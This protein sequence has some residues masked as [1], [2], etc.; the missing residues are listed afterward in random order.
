MAKCA[1]MNMYYVRAACNVVF[2]Q[3]SYRTFLKLCENWDVSKLSVPF[4]STPNSASITSLLK[5]SLILCLNHARL[6]NII[7]QRNFEK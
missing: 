7:L 2:V 1:C 6:A 3:G 5:Y 4:T